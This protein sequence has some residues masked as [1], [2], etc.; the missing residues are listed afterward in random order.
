MIV[1]QRKEHGATGVPKTLG[2]NDVQVGWLMAIPV[3]L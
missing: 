3:V 1:H 2:L